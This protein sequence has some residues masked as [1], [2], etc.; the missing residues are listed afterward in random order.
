MTLT[1]SDYYCDG[2]SGHAKSWGRVS[3]LGLT[4]SEYGGGSLTPYGA[5]GSAV[6]GW[7]NVPLQ[8]G[9]TSIDI[10]SIPAATR[11]RSALR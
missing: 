6:P 11:P 8:A 3:L 5:D 2:Q 9:S 1:P 10:S 4:G 7:T